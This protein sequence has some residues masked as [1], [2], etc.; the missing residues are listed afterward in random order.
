MSVFV[1]DVLLGVVVLIVP[2]LCLYI[3]N[4]TTRPR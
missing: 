3:V 1:W 4:T 2:L